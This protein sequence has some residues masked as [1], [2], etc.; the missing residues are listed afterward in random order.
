MNAQNGPRDVG[1]VLDARYWLTEKG[2]AA[3]EEW[4]AAQNA[5]DAQ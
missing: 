4:W 3:T 5:E 1:S 2:E